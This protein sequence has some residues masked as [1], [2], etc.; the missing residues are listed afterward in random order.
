MIRQLDGSAP[1]CGWIVDLRANPGGNMSP[2]L[3]GLGPV[4]GSGVVGYFVDPDSA[5]TS[6]YYRAGEAGINLAPSGFRVSAPYELR[7][8]DP[9][10]AVLTGS[11]T[12]SSGEAIA[13]A[14]RGRPETR[15]F[16]AGTAGL[17][18]G[19][20]GIRLRDGAQIGLATSVF[21]DRTRRVYGGVIEPDQPV[22]GTMR[23]DPSSGDAGVDA[24]AAWLLGRPACR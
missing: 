10:V 19:V 22:G 9:P 23:E 2:M 14:F 11:T 15:S 1:T 3:L 8:P 16:G 4:V 17:S 18:T 20:A 13:T 5:W 7:R 12:A 24:A 6:W 21:A